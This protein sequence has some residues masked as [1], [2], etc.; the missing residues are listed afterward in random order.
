MASCVTRKPNAALEDPPI[1]LTYS[2][3]LQ[4]QSQSKYFNQGTRSLSPLQ[5][6]ETVRMRKGGTW[7]EKAKVVEKMAPT[8]YKVET[9]QEEVYGRNRH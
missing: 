8:S 9:E 1:Q 2:K 4:Q 7:S 6:G 5:T 3:A